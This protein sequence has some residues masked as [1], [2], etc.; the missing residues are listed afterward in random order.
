MCVNE[1]VS[2]CNCIRCIKLLYISIFINKY[3]IKI[4]ICNSLN[5]F[6]AITI[7]YRV[8]HT[9]AIKTTKTTKTKPTQKMSTIQENGPAWRSAEHFLRILFGL[10]DGQEKLFPA[11]FP[12]NFP[13]GPNSNDSDDWG[14]GD[15]P[16]GP[17]LNDSDEWGDGGYSDDEDDWYYQYNWDKWYDQGYEAY[18]DAG[19]GKSDRAVVYHPKDYNPSYAAWLRAKTPPQKG[20]MKNCAKHAQAQGLGRSKFLPWN[21]NP[22]P[23]CRT[24]S[25]GETLEHMKEKPSNNRNIAVKKLARIERAKAN[26]NV[27]IVNHR[28]MRGSSNRV[29]DDDNR[30][31]PKSTFKR[32]KDSRRSAKRFAREEHNRWKRGEHTGF[33]EPCQ[34][35]VKRIR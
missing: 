21:G 9:Y 33:C 19:Y 34:V 8:I 6:N 23:V 16:N 35:I 27:M 17:N 30:K 7:T 12:A 11:H 24:G 32:R 1:F 14:D 18:L 10:C 31:F 5:G 28:R 20:F 29:P 15:F 2:N 22:A 26:G 13:N 3:S 25:G 4:E